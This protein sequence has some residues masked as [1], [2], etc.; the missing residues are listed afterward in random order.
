MTI[1]IKS[2]LLLTPD[3][4]V[5]FVASTL[6]PGLAGLGFSVWLLR[7]MHIGAI[8]KCCGRWL[9]QAASVCSTPSTNRTPAMT[10]GSS[11]EPF[12]NRQLFAAPSISL[13]TI[14]RQADLDPLPFVFAVRS[15]TVA[16][17]DSMGLVV[18][19]WTQCSAGKS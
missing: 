13:N 12:S 5:C 17:V 6:Y 3:P 11:S 1:R 4:V 15:R 10:F 19:R 14:V 18:R 8:V 2:L 7:T 9:L 16:N